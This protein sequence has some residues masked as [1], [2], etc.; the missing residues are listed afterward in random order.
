MS[1]TRLKE[2]LTNNRFLT[3]VLTLA[4]ATA[5]GQFILLLALPL[6]TRLYT[7]DE[8]GLLAVFTAVVGA[9]LVVSSLRYEIA[10]P[11]PRNAGSARQLLYLALAINLVVAVFSFI[12]I[13][14][15]RED[16]AHAVQSPQLSTYLWLLPPGILFAGTYKALSYWAIRIKDYP[17]L[18]RTK[19]VQSLANVATQVLAGSAGLG[20]LGLI[21]GQV[22]GQ[23]AGAMRLL[24]GAQLQLAF[25]PARLT[26]ARSFALLRRHRHFPK[27]DAPAAVIDVLSIQLPNLLLAALFSPMVAGLYMLAERVLTAPMGLLG[28]AVGQV[29]YGSSRDAIQQGTLEQL[30]VRILGTLSAFIILPAI[31]LFFWAETLFAWIF[32]DIWR[33]SGLYASW[34]ILGLSVQFLYSPI[35]MVL[36]ATNGQR[37]NL[38]IHVFMLLTKTGAV[39]LGYHMGSPVAAIIG[40][41]VAG[42]VGYALAI[43]IIL[44]HARNYRVRF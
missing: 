2:R 41:S 39:V 12:F 42:A 34:L 38:L 9:V 25:S 26:S 21:L 44:A 36:M 6:L 32:G 29:L 24:T 4:S 18:A 40:F 7:P 19:I 30:A 10:I 31:A 27:Y 37:I 13:A 28:Q 5:A 17:A 15:F 3:G 35:S 14:L 1:L 23:A 8:F 22:I 20:A 33:Q 16:L 43:C 11:L